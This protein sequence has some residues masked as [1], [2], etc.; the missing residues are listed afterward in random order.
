VQLSTDRG[1]DITGTHAPEESREENTQEF[2]EMLQ[3]RIQKINKI[4]ICV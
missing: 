1:I 3:D 2:N 4:I